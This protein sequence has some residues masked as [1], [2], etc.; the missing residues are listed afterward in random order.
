MSMK[1]LSTLCM[2]FVLVIGGSV[3]LC[4]QVRTQ[5]PVAR[6]P[7]R[8]ALPAVQT[9][10]TV[11]NSPSFRWTIQDALVQALR[12]GVQTSR[13]SS[14]TGALNGPQ[15][16]KNS[17]AIMSAASAIRQG[18]FGDG[19]VLPVRPGQTMSAPGTGSAPRTLGGAAGAS[20][21]ARVNSPTSGAKLGT[22]LNASSFSKACAPGSLGI[23]NVDHQK[24][25]YFIF[26][27]LSSLNPYRIG[28]CGFGDKPGQVWLT[29]VRNAHAMP[30]TAGGNASQ[31][32]SYVGQHPGWM[33]LNVYQNHW[34]NWSIDV[35]VDPN[36]SGYLHTENVTLLVITA[37]G[38]Q[39]TATGCVFNPV[40]V[41]QRLTSIPQNLLVSLM[42]AS[43]ITTISQYAG[44]ASLAQVSDA[45][46][47]RVTS[48]IFSPSNGSLVLPGH[49][50]AV[51][52]D[53]NTAPF[54]GGTDTFDFI[55]RL[56]ITHVDLFHSSLSPQACQSLLPPQAKY[57]TSGN[58]LFTWA[59]SPVK[60][61]I[62][63]Q[64]QSCTTGPSTGS[65]SIYALDLYVLTARG[66]D[67]WTTWQKQN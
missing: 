6:Q 24:P 15:D 46:G 42:G 64:E 55:G 66:V 5:L 10:G 1:S 57:T 29:G 31:K 37:D 14:G 2:P 30:V 45:A 9:G 20:S 34:S 41:E 40:F 3:A 17:A 53:D 21:A 32:F 22:G 19:S 23:G 59:G 62:S 39:Y 16:F 35:N 60:F 8:Q 36:T 51:V 33:K 7:V 27:P 67:P 50:L 65:A 58:W 12:R 38:H 49:T 43:S 54:P 61:T 44:A 28:G 13:G 47:H 63:W 26:S 18:T 11:A 4:A 48:Y 25:L 52:R 56:W